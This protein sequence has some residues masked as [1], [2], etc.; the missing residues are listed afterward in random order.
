MP[1]G[2]ASASRVFTSSNPAIAEVKASG[3]IV[4]AVKE[5]AAVVTVKTFN[6]IFATCTVVVNVQPEE[7]LD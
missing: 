7:N 5:G 3:G 4:T 2:Q 6:R 1:E